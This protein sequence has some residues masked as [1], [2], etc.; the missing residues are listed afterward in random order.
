MGPEWPTLITGEQF[1]QRVSMPEMKFGRQV[2]FGKLTNISSYNC[3]V[4]FDYYQTHLVTEVTHLRQSKVVSIC[5]NSCRA[6]RVCNVSIILKHD[7]V[8]T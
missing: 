8:G 6:Y 4:Q 7:I 3:T 1:A 5:W 2:V